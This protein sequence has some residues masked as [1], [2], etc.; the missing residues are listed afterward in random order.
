MCQQDAHIILGQEMMDSLVITLNHGMNV[1]MKIL[2]EVEFIWSALAFR[3][4]GVGR[5]LDTT[6]LLLLMLRLKFRHGIRLIMDG[7]EVPGQQMIIS[8]MNK[9][10][11]IWVML[12]LV[13]I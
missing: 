4:E 3:R 5:L 12:M 11:A 10:P 8:R 13:T 2:L 7:G 9:Y 6:L 1:L